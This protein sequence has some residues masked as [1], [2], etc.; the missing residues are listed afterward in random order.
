MN[1]FHGALLGIIQGLAEFLPVSSSGHLLLARFL[2][3]IQG[4]SPETQSALKMLDILLHVGTL[5]WGQEL[6]CH[7]MIAV[8]PPKFIC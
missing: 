1:V 5:I 2:L 8:S 3:G 6:E 4:N 7:R